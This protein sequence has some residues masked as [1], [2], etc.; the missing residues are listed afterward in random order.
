MKGV[1][2]T[3][4]GRVQIPVDAEHDV[5]F[6][7]GFAAISIFNGAGYLNGTSF[8]GDFA[9]EFVTLYCAHLRR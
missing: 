7:A 5:L 3:T 8:K 1:Q 9:S 6:I 4:F 2:F